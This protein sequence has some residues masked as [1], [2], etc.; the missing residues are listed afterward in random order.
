MNNESA[1]NFCISASVRQV[2]ALSSVSFNVTT[3][4][5]IELR[6]R[7][8]IH[9]GPYA[10]AGINIFRIITALKD[11]LKHLREGRVHLEQ[12]KVLQ[13]K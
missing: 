10:E 5:I 12:G 3:T 2:D 7:N 1:C 9:V 11:K 4:R 13:T 6:N 8:Q